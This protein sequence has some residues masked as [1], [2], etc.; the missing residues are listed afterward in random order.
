MKLTREYTEVDGYTIYSKRNY[1][2]EL[3]TYQNMFGLGMNKLF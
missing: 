3:Y 2:P 1:D